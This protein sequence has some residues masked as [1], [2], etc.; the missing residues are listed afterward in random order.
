[1]TVRPKGRKRKYAEYDE[2][3]QSLPKV[4]TKRP[5]YLN[6]I[7]IFRGA[8]GDTAWLKV[9][10]PHGSNYKG[11]SYRPGSSVEIK[12]G[13]LASWPWQELE[14]ELHNFQRKADRGE[15]LEAQQQPLLKDWATDWLDRSES[16]VKDHAT[17]KIHINKHIIPALGKKTLSHIGVIDINKWISKQLKSLEPGTVKR[18][19]N[20]LKACLNDAIR[21]G[22]IEKNPCDNSDKIRGI[23]RRQ[24]FLDAEEI[25]ILLSKA[26]EEADWLADLIL[27]YLH[28]GMRKNEALGLNWS[29][30]RNLNNGTTI[31]ELG[32]SKGDD[33]RHVVCTKTMKEIIERQRSRKKEGDERLFPYAEITIRRKWKKVREEAGLSDVVMH[34]LRRTHGTHAATAGVDLRTLAGRMGHSDLDM[35]QKH[36]AALVGS[37]AEDAANKIEEAF[38]AK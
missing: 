34:D 23:N 21:T 36:Y 25:L 38:S 6:G 22:H 28:S 33:G 32:L 7:G 1:M 16:R 12:V 15:P 29:N 26:E 30:V 31:I 18:Q 27:W 35:L 37:A 17:L 5:K 20:T 13:N 3:L 9:N 19:H 14:E 2:L 11:K 24:R 10:L 4:M 8:R